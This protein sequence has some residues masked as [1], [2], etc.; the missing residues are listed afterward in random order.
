MRAVLGSIPQMFVMAA[1]VATALCV[2]VFAL[3]ALFAYLAFGIPVHG[4]LTFGESINAVEGIVAW[5]AVMLVPSL[6]YAAYGM[7]WIS[8][9]T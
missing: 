2:P 7:P 8:D 5:W 1:I 4:F 9:R 3:L 6:V